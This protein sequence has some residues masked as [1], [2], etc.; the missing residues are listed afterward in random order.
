MEDIHDII[1]EGN[2][3]CRLL[4]WA[5]SKLGLVHDECFLAFFQKVGLSGIVEAEII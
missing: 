2:L 1:L 5:H 3:E 4:T